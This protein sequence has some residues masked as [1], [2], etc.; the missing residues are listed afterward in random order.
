[1]KWSSLLNLH[2]F[3]FVCLFKYF[4]GKINTEID[5]LTNETPYFLVFGRMPRF[6]SGV[7]EIKYSEQIQ[8]DSEEIE[9]EETQKSKEISEKT[10]VSEMD[11]GTSGNFWCKNLYF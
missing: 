1:M 9:Q 2:F 7:D 11:A 3:V 5:P 8:E 4:L 6:D 10:Q